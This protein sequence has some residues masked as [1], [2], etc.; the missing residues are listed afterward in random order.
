MPGMDLMG[1][2]RDE[3]ETEIGVLRSRRI[4]EAVLDSLSF[5]VRLKNPAGVRD[6]VISV[7]AIGENSAD[8][9]LKFVRAADNRFA[10]T[11]EKLKGAE[12]VATTV[13]AGDSLRV[14]NVSIY[15]NPVI[16]AELKEFELVLLPR[17][18][19][20]KRFDDILDIRQQEGGSRLVEVS[21]EEEDRVEAARAVERI[22]A[23]YVA[24]T[25][26]NDASDDQFRTVELKRAVDSV[27]KD[28]AK[29]ETR[30]RAFKENEKILVPD[31]QATQQLKRIAVLRTQLD[32][33]EVEHNALS[34]MLAIIN[35]RSNSGRSSEAY[36]QLATFPS[37][38]ANKAIQDYLAN[39]AELENARSELGVRR[40][41]ENDEMRQ[42]TS[43]ITEL[44]QQLNRVGTQYE[45]SLEQQIAVAT[46]SV[47]SMTSELDVFPRQ[48][49]EYVKLLRDRTIWNEGFIILQ[50]QLKQAEIS[51]ALRTEKVRVVD[52]ARVAD[53]KDVEFPKP[54]VQLLLGA[55]LGAAVALTIAFGREILAGNP[56][57]AST[58]V[59]QK[60]GSAS[61]P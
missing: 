56:D 39:L 40:T 6:S 7:R 24:Y 30:L 37:L 18:K 52:S 50:K 46:Q 10:V 47:K 43:R 32:G 8:G 27:G 22:V 57:H 60:S 44:E 28:L 12:F 41:A 13:G 59:S 54:I 58:S 17:F 49:M 53:A 20:L 4:A 55:I 36:R 11:A 38:I 34:K 42:I 29:A 2:G 21:V 9:K 23:E 35:S 1:L 33:L 48:E 25:N 31:E 26:V 16:D 3:L 45:E 51:A 15:L 19:A 5:M 61:A 14:G